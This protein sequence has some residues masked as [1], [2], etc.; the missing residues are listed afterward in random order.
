MGKIM[1]LSFD[2]YRTLIDTR[3]FHEQA[4]REILTREDVNSVDPDH[5]HSRW[6]E[7]YDDM[8]QALGPDGF[9]SERDIGVESL[10]RAF[11]EFGI[12]GDPETGVNIWLSKYGN[13]VLYPE[14]EEVL[15]IL[16]AKYP[17]VVISNVDDDDIGYAMFRAKSLPFRAIITSESLR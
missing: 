13:A 14:A 6:D 15:H 4:I 2:M 16:A 17:M 5:F 11:R 12:N 7:I 1:A 10:R 9:M 8:H 3:D